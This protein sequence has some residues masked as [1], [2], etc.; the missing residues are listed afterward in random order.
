VIFA[1]R[2]LASLSIGILPSLIS[3]NA[4]HTFVNGRPSPC[5]L[6]VPKESQIH[7]CYDVVFSRI[8]NVLK[9]ELPCLICPFGVEA[10]IAQN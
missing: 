5:A 10:V 1:Q 8:F 4:I 7:E 3:G 2:Y 6:A 9:G